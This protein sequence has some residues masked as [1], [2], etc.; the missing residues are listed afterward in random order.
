MILL[1]VPS[2]SK[3]QSFFS[4]ESPGGITTELS[5]GII[6]Q[7]A[8]KQVNELRCSICGTPQISREVLFDHEIK[9]ELEQAVACESEAAYYEAHKDDL[10]IKSKA[11]HEAHK[12]DLAIKSKAY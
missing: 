11:Y 4:S 2:H 10:A 9:C 8:P 7:H 5:Q 3:P 1:P 6:Y 12:D